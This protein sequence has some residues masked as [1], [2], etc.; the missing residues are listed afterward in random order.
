MHPKKE[1]EKRVMEK[2]VL[3][4]SASEVVSRRAGESRRPMIKSEDERSSFEGGRKPVGTKKV[5][6][7]GNRQRR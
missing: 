1:K 2:T 3:G 6:D 4:P 7:G 5:R